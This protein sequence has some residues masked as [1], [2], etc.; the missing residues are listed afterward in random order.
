MNGLHHIGL[1]V[2]EI[3]KSISFYTNNLGFSLQERWINPRNGAQIA[4]LNG[5]GCT[6]ELIEYVR[7]D[8]EGERPYNHIA[9]LV[10]HVEKIMEEFQRKSIWL[11][12]D[13][14]RIIMQGRGKIIFCCGPDGELIELHQRLD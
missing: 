5:F 8:Y 7:D 4:L 3:E 2:S 9:V 10:D 6:Y 13:A 1:V 11:D 12:G 14:P